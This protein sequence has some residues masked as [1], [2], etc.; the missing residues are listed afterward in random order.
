[1]TMN[2]VTTSPVTGNIKLK[3]K[4]LHVK[5][6]LAVATAAL[7]FML[8]SSYFFYQRIYQSSLAES[9]RSVKQ[10]LETVSTTAAIAAYV[11][12]KE[13][14]QEV[15]SGLTKNDIV[16]GAEIMANGERIG[17][18]GRPITNDKPSYASLK[19]KA[20]FDPNETVGELSVLT[21]LPLIAKR[22][23]DSALVTT[24]SLAA[25]A[26]AVAFLVLFLVYWMMTRPLSS[27]SN[28]LHG[29]IPGDGKRLDVLKQHKSDEIGLLVNDINSLLTTVD[30]MLHEERQLRHRVELLEHRFR[31][32]FEDSSAGIFLVRENGTMVTANPAFF[33]LTK[34]FKS[35]EDV[36]LD[37]NILNETFV[38]PAQALGLIKLTIVS[39]RP[40]SCDL[41]ISSSD[42]EEKDRWVHCIFSRAGE[43]QSNPVVEGV[44]YDITQRKLAEDITRELAEKD[45]LTGLANRQAAELVLHDLAQNAAHSGT[46][47]VVMLIDLDRF[48]F[49][50]DTYGHDA[51]DWV[52]QQ[53]ADRLHNRVRSTDVVAR[54][55]GD[56]FLV[57]LTQTDNQ[58]RVKELAEKLLA[59]QQQPMEVQPGFFETIAMSIGIA[60]YDKKE[61]N[62]MSIRKH[63]DQAMYAVKRKGKNGYAIYSAIGK[64]EI[65]LEDNKTV[66]QN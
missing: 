6:S 16:I 13:L 20:P 57:I 43:D 9:E 66:L 42:G 64:H 51:G 29:I 21:N 3:L 54:L 30:K 10:L 63:A 5:V 62:E 17:F 35:V 45:S 38:D 23:R 48:K 7:F 65:F 37:T 28:R 61:D 47:F 41:K 27:L 19:L 55:G 40:C 24:M 12:N 18:Q 11:F 39:H 58:S 44:M 46:G 50:N 34:K 15:V 26:A 14:A 32:I 22:A 33:K 8:V 59:D 52:L 53:V 4:S 2:T 56:E 60:F 25:Q 49:I 1:M 31:G 36:A